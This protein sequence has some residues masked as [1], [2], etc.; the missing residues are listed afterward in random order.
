M[1]LRH[2]VLGEQLALADAIEVLSPLLSDPCVLKVLQNAKFD[3]QV[4]RPGRDFRS[5]CQ[6]TTPMLISFVQD[7]G[8]HCHGMHELA[9]LQL[10]HSPISN[11]D[12]TGTGRNRVSFAEVP[13]ER[14]T[15]YAAEDADVTFRLWEALHPRMRA[16]KAL[17][18]YE[19]MERRLADPDSAGHGTSRREGRR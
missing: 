11:D 19:Q 14:A 18:L 8:L 16:A 7:A 6:W 12:F 2:T 15:A 3:M 10:G 9:R 5:L 13:I 4:L 1:P 17:A